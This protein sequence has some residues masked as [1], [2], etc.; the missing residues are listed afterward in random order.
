MS[1]DTVGKKCCGCGTCVTVCPKT[2]ISIINDEY[3]FEYP[4]IDQNRCISCGLCE[5]VCPAIYQQLVNT[6]YQCGAAYALDEKLKFEGSSGGLF[7]VFARQVIHEGGIVF[8]AAF[9]AE[10][11]LK[12]VSAETEEELKP[13]FKSKYLLCNTDNQFL[14]IKKELG[15]GRKVLYCSSPCQVSALRL[16]L[17]NDYN[18]LITIDFVCH[19]VGS[20]SLFNKSI[21]WIEKTTGNKIKHFQFRYKSKGASSHYYRYTSKGEKHTNEGLYLTFPYYNAYCKQLIYRESCYT[22]Q[23]AQE[24]RTS[25]ITIGDFHTIER[26]DKTVDRFAGISMFVCNSSKGMDFFSSVREQL[27]IR[28]FEWNVLKQ[29]NRFSNFNDYRPPEQTTFMK[30]IAEDG[31]E[32]TVRRFLNPKKDWKRMLYYNSPKWARDFAKGRLGE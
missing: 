7:G 19:G 13:L 3:G 30:S 26:F 25:D 4:Y 20:Q 14:S 22:C 2:A 5:K 15:A 28:E 1:I 23:Y 27:W 16:F 21:V 31:F 29:E 24:E 11:R 17:G 18:S 8:G 32:A 12:T 10:L 9:D 6:R